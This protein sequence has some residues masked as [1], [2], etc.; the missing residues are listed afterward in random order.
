MSQA[1]MF[2]KDVACKGHAEDV[3]DLNNVPGVH[4]L[5]PTANPLNRIDSIKEDAALARASSYT[6]L[7]EE[8]LL[9]AQNLV[10]VLLTTVQG[11]NV[12]GCLLLL[13]LSHWR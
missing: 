3:A 12:S 6:G 9:G 4:V 7:P 2:V 8:Q 10:R 5:A 1:C 11:G 13:L